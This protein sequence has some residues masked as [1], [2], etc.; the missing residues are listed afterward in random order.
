MNTVL[1]RPPA[2]CASSPS[3]PRPRAPACASGPHGA[4]ALR[5]TLYR[6]RCYAAEALRAA[7]LPNLAGNIVRAPDTDL[8]VLVGRAR[9]EVRR[10]L[11][12]AAHAHQLDVAAGAPAG[13]DVEVQRYKRALLALG[14]V[15]A[16]L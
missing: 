16:C 5:G 11:D 6:R 9:G 10:R 8:E 13:R 12:A 4:E 14:E 1:L 3:A 15:W 7:G 2:T